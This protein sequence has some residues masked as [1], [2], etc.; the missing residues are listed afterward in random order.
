MRAYYGELQ[1]SVQFVSC[2]MSLYYVIEQA[3]VILR[4]LI[5]GN[6]DH[7]P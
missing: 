5:Y 2:V 3:L 4:I 6:L 7:G 1:N